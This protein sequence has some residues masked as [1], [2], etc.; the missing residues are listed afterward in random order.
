MKSLL[1]ALMLGIALLSGSLIAGDDDL[2]KLKIQVTTLNGR[3][4]DQASVVVRF[5]K[6]RSITKLGTKVMPRWELRT[7]REGLVE[8]PPIPKGEITVQV[9]AKGYQTYGE[10]MEIEES[11]KTLQIKMKPPQA[12]YTSHQ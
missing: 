1:S 5:V 2:T 3:P 6:G 12:Q 7:N 9:I 10:M 8:I 11:E 4:I